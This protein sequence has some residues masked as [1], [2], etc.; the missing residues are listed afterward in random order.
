MA[1]GAQHIAD[2]SSVERITVPNI[3]ALFA[4]LMAG[5]SKVLVGRAGQSTVE[6]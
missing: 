2:V 1:T 6:S 4:R 5:S 3:E